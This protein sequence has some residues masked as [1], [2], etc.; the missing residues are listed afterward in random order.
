[1]P[2]RLVVREL[3]IDIDLISFS[4][5]PIHKEIVSSEQE[6]I[7]N[8]F[9]GTTVLTLIGDSPELI[10]F[11][12]NKQWFHKNIFKWIFILYCTGW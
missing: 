9:T 2:A 12:T 1:M 6:V 7:T 10:K 4:I 8:I 11:S 5:L 3:D